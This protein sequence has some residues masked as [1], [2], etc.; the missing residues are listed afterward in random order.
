MLTYRNNDFFGLVDGL[1]FALQYQGKNDS[2]TESNNGRDVLAQNGDGYGMSATYDLG[3]GISAAA[4]T[5]LLT[6]PTS[7]MAITTRVFWAAATRL[8]P[9]AAA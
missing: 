4:L 8:K 2:A 5:S 3:Y 9:T 7:R 6:V 1:N